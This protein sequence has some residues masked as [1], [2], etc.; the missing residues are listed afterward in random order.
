MKQKEAM[1]GLA[2]AEF[3]CVLYIVCKLTGYF[4]DSYYFWIAGIAIFAAGLVLP[5]IALV[6]GGVNGWFSGV[7]MGILGMGLAGLFLVCLQEM[8]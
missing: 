2:L 8:P 5:F 6:R 1:L 7:I 3:L 4:L